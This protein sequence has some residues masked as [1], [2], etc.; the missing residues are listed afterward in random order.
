[1][2]TDRMKRLLILGAGFLQSFV[3]K[4]AKELG[5]YTIAA[6][7]NPS[8]LGFQYADDYGI[9]D[10]VDPEECLK[11]AIDKK[12]DGIMTAATDHG[13]LAAS[14]VAQQLG[15][16]GINFDSAKLIKNK[17]SVRK[18]FVENSID[19]VSQ[20]YEVKSI[21]D[22]NVIM[23][24]IKYPVMVKPCD[25]SGSK[26]IKRVDRSEQLCDAC[27]EAIEASLIKKALIED[28]IMGKEYGVESFVYKGEVYVLGIMNKEMT[29]PPDYAELGHMIPSGLEIENKIKEIV[30][31]AIKLLGVNFG[32]INMDILVTEENHVCII[33]VGA[34]MGGNLIGSH[35]I[36]KATEYDYLGNLI[37]ATVNDDIDIPNS[38]V[39][40]S[41]AT[42]ILALTPGKI[43]SLPDFNTI[44]RD[45]NVDIFFN[46]AVGEFIRLYHNNLDGCGYILS[47]GKNLVN[48]ENNAIKAKETLNEEINRG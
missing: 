11:F 45:C 22:L 15:L 35:I 29:S 20:Y 41:V 31:N 1:M 36:S 8:S 38:N 9:V 33:D 30:K 6:D 34:R 26:A 19:D 2:E 23:N 12:I 43:L 10:I 14:Y 5:Y 17:Y 18:L 3:I 39:L 46:K 24:S 7:K 25:G 47:V 16:L 32:A 4:K 42:R 21:D 48:V 44:M 13:V 37:K 27:K 40:N 28:F